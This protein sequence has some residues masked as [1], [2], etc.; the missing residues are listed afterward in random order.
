MTAT[1][2][3]SPGALLPLLRCGTAPKNR[4]HFSFLDRRM[5]RQEVTVV[6]TDTMKFYL[7]WLEKQC[8]L[9]RHPAT[10]NPSH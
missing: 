7:N 8:L 10:K 4:L 6:P 9:R 3:V 5:I 2:S 1:L